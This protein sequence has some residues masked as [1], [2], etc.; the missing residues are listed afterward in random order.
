MSRVPMHGVWVAAALA[1]SCAG[2]PPPVTDLPD[3]PASPSAEEAPWNPRFRYLGTEVEAA[4]SGPTMGGSMEHG[5]EAM[6]HALPGTIVDHDPPTE[7]SASNQGEPALDEGA[8]HE[9]HAIEQGHTSSS[10]EDPIEGGYACPMHPEVG[11][12]DRPGT[13]PICGRVLEPQP[14]PARAADGR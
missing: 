12:E 14:S 1:A 13:C 11:R 5:D 8:A 10:A 6:Q 9:G 3:N 2:V 4:A 7:S